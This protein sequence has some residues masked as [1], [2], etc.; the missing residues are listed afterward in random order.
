MKQINWTQVELDYRC[1]VKSLRTIAAGSG[2]TEGAIR[3]RAKKEGWERDLSAKIK[4]KAESLV[5]KAEVRQE[6]RNQMSVLET[7]EIAINA[8]AVADVIMG[9]RSGARRMKSMVFALLEE[10]ELEGSNKALLEN[11]AELME[12]NE[13][14][15]SKRLEV[16]MKAISLPSR[17]ISAERLVNAYAKLVAIDLEAFGI[18]REAKKPKDPLEE[19]TEEELNAEISRVYEKIRLAGGPS[20]LIGK[21]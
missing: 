18:D 21:H 15:G 12:Q 17:V 6:V 20:G 2:V 14:I 5:R 9:H 4:A 3:K 7:T 1:G 11:L 10:I 13:E 16:V 8:Q 19:L